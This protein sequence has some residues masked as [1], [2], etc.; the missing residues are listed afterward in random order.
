MHK[1]LD[2]AIAQMTR[3]ARAIEL[4]AGV[5]TKKGEVDSSN[6]TRQQSDWS[7]DAGGAA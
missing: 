3:M 1:K 2:Y 7:R 6:A 4:L 5:Q